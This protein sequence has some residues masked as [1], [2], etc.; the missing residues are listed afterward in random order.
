MKRIVSLSLVASLALLGCDNQTDNSMLIGYIE[1]DW[2]YSAPPQAGWIREM[3]VNEGQRVSAGEALYRL[4]DE[5][6]VA[7]LAEAE[8]RLHQARENADDLASG[9]RNEEILRLEARLAQ[10]RANLSKAKSDQERVLPLVE[11]GI[12][13]ASRRDEVVAQFE[14][15]EAAVNTAQREI[16]VAELAARPA[17]REAAQAA[18]DAALASVASASYQLQERT[19]SAPTEGRVEKL[20][21]RQGE[22]ATAGAAVLAILPDDALKVVFF[23]PQ[24]VL[25]SVNLGGIIKVYAD[26]LDSSLEGHIHFIAESAEFTPPIIYSRDARGDLVFRV[27]ARIPANSGLHAGLPVDIQL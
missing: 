4:D 20:F 22:F 6:Q 15:A 14:L 24:A 13:P 17:Q 19:V 18:V 23:V 3:T 16:E 2:I 12:E 5:A 26:G 1:A 21:L 9:A 7:A 8:A 11:R 25:P 10:A 27:E